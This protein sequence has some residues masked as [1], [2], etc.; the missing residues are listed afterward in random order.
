MVAADLRPTAPDPVT[1]SSTDL[2]RC[3]AAARSPEAAGPRDRRVDGVPDLKKKHEHL[4]LRL[5]LIYNR[6]RYRQKDDRE[7][8]CH[9][10]VIGKS[11]QDSL[12]ANAFN[13][14]SRDM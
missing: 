8:I 4:P 11:T 9:L 2:R 14:Q 1:A 12:A 3:R 7:R 13:E 10:D 5:I 6:Q